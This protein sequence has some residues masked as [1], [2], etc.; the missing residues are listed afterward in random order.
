MTLKQRKMLKKW[1]VINQTPYYKMKV[2]NVIRGY[3]GYRG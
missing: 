3:R 2:N 1:E